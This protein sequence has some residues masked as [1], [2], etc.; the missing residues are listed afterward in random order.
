MAM[1]VR[2]FEFWGRARFI[3]VR[4]KQI[5]R[6]K[7]TSAQLAVVCFAGEDYTSR[8]T[9]VGAWLS[10]FDLLLLKP[11]RIYGLTISMGWIRSMTCQVTAAACEICGFD[12]GGDR[13][14]A[15]ETA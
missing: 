3:P 5:P 2:E 9:G 6:W 4:V 12:V 1:R 8:K 13:R 10:I 15:T 11:W 14:R 7:F